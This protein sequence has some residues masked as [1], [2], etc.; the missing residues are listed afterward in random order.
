MNDIE[1]RMQPTLSI[2]V[3][4]HNEEGNLEKL[5]VEL[6]D[7]LS[8]VGST[9]EIIIVDDGSTDGTWKKVEALHTSDPRVRGLRLSRN[10]G[11]QSALMAGLS[12]ANG[13][14]IA[15]MDAD[16]QHPPAVLPQLLEQWRQGKLIVKTVRLDSPSTPAF[17]RWTSRLFYRVFSYLSGVEIR[18]GTSDFRLLDRKVLDEILRFKEDGLF[19]RGIVEWV[20][21]PIATVTFECGE[22]YAG[23]TKYTLRKMLRFA[24]HGI[25]SFSLVPLRLVTLLGITASAIA[26]LAVGYAILSKLLVGHAVP[27]W[28]SS[29][30]IIS[31]LFGVLFLNLAIVSEYLGRVLQEV[32]GRPRFI[33]SEE[34]GGSASRLAVPST[35]IVDHRSNDTGES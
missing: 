18:E 19:L 12:T 10:F 22:R 33:V 11:H 4:A 14:A 23:S 16:L 15:S 20:G 9:W 8:T 27:G 21:Y 35:L 13:D 17:K 25:S 3:P 1:K 26:F 30:A 7:A 24:W 28:A 34:T 2:V 6:R 31:F 32:R 5:F 29:V